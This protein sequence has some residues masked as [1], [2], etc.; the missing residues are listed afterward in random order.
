VARQLEFAA[1]IRNPELNARPGDVEPRRMQIYLDLFYNNIESFLASAFPVS[2]SLLG[3]ERWH[4][5]VRAFVHR[6]PS[7][8]PY[9]LEISQEFLTF[10]AGAA[11]TDPALQEAVRPPPFL[12][13][14][15]HYEWVELAM[16]V[17]EEEIPE[18]GIDRSGDLLS[19]VPVISPLI[20]K[21]AYQYPVHQI[22]PRFQPETPEVAP[23]QLVVYRRRDDSVHFMTVAPLTMALLDE[24]EV[25]QSGRQALA[26]VAERVPGLSVDIA[27]SR[28]L[29]TLEQLRNAEIV[30]GSTKAD[31][32]SSGESS[33]P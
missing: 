9:F 26:R 25:P 28:G 33:S 2:K 8:S 15:C 18:S 31:T 5:L 11:V 32:V 19:G 1:H 22:G 13:E 14:L 4:L 10:L 27:Y 24:L 6:H 17:A 3:D 23:T 20:W 29:E 16:A 30:L 21:L 12:L 7:E